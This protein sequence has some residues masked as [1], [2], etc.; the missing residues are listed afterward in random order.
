MFEIER[1]LGF[2]GLFDGRKEGT[3]TLKNPRNGVFAFVL[4]GAFE[5]EDRL[6]EAK[7]GLAL[8]VTHKIEWEALSENAILLVIEVPLNH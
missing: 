6:L 3:F 2:I 7:D 4:S 8:K 1:A 5:I